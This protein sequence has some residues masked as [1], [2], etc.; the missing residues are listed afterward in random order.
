MHK[1]AFTTALAAASLGLSA[2]GDGGSNNSADANLAGDANGMAADIEGEAGANGMA[3]NAGAAAGGAATA[4]ADWPRGTRIVQE[5]GATYRVNA[6]GRRVRIENDDVRIVTDNGVRYRVNRE[7]NR[8]RID[9]RGID[10]DL[11]A[12]SVPGV[13]VDVGTNRKGN[14]DV[15]VSTNGTDASRDR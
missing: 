9:E 13:D 11:D 7:G 2:C 6:D 15:D 3:G 5:G 14:L 8:V 12:P 10:V 1:I 4:S